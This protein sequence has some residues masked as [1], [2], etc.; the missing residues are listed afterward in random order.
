MADATTP[1]KSNMLLY[2]ALA[3]GAA[4]V[5]LNKGTA[6]ATSATSDPNSWLNASGASGGAQMSLPAGIAELAAKVG[7]DANTVLTI[8]KDDATRW[9]HPDKLS[10]D[11][12][13]NDVNVWNNAVR[14]YNAG[15]AGLPDGVIQVAMQMGLDPAQVLTIAKDDA[16]RW[17]HPD[18]L[19]TD[20]FLNDRTVW[21]NAV[22]AYQTGQ[23]GPAAT[24]P[25]VAATSAPATAGSAPSAPAAR[26]G[27]AL[28]GEPDIVFRELSNWQNANGPN[29]MFD[30]QWGDGSRNVRLN[31]ARMAGQQYHIFVEDLR[32]VLDFRMNQ[33]GIGSWD[34]LYW[35]FI[36]DPGSMAAVLTAYNQKNGN[37]IAPRW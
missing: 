32:A 20:M 2:L 35:S 29:Q 19:S 6:S 15:Q 23:G 30:T 25:A 11:M 5:F 4:Y 21:D 1:A 3:G 22:N 16:V 8:A 31:L 26:P 13:L 37:N 24:A 33:G 34:D 17:G 27:F 7:L 36:N 28:D 12:F 14:I 10:T 18:T 9:G